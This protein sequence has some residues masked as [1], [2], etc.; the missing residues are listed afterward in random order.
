MRAASVYVRNGDKW[1]GAY[2]GETLITDPKN[3]QKM[4]PPAPPPAEKKDSNTASNSNAGVKPA[5]PAP[6]P[7]LDVIMAVEESARKPGK[8]A[9]SKSSK[10]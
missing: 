5:A 4:P 7:N 8:P 2:H 6:D 10:K 9:T 3:P 1:V